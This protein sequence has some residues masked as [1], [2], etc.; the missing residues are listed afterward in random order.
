LLDTEI[1]VVLFSFAERFAEQSESCRIAIPLAMS[2]AAV[3]DARREATTAMPVA[4]LEIS[5]F[6]SCDSPGRFRR[7]M[8]FEVAF[9]ASIRIVLV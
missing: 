7:M 3:G 9:S 4:E 5:C 6:A 8:L 1:E 2:N